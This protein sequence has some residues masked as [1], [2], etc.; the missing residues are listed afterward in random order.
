MRNLRDALKGVNGGIASAGALLALLTWFFPELRCWFINNGLAGWMTAISIVVIFPIVASV[1]S[2]VKE[3]RIFLIKDYELVVKRLGGW[4][5]ESDFYNYLRNNTHHNHFRQSI[6]D[7]IE[8][9]CTEWRNDNREIKNKKLESAF[10]RTKEAANAY[11]IKLFELTWPVGNSTGV[12]ADFD[13]LH[14]PPE[15]EHEDPERFTSA[16]KELR[17]CWLNF[18]NALDSIFTLLHNIKPISTSIE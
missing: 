16:Y 13:Y 14:V 4:T 7:E 5:L 10:N 6:Y 15:W 3:M 12:P 2:A 9:R 1:E 18:V 11:Q 17:A 8:N